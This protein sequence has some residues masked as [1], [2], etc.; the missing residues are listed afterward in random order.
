MGKFEQML[1]EAK[2][3]EE[4]IDG[5]EETEEVDGAEEKE[6]KKDKKDKK[7]DIKLADVKAFLKSAS[8]KDLEAC[9]KEIEKALEDEEG[10]EAPEADMEVEE[11]KDTFSKVLAKYGI[12]KQNFVQ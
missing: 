11:G 6:E 9:A 4:E 5:A 3:N 7:K 12:K 10:E 2:K 1:A 8:K